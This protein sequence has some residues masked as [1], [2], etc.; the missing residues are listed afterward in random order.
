MQIK[1]ITEFLAKNKFTIL[2]I[3]LFAVIVLL[4]VTFIGSLKKDYLLENAKREIQLK[5]E[6]R[7][8]IIAQRAIWEKMI[9]GI[10]EN[11][12]RLNTNDS[13]IRESIMMNTQQIEKVQNKYN[14]K[15]KV[16]QH[17]N[18]ADLQRYFGELPDQ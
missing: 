18:S 1:K 15:I 7:Q 8:E 17:Y 2:L 5:E 10:N 16:V 4:L 9:T 11:I 6:A 12:S 3:V 14:E 13:L